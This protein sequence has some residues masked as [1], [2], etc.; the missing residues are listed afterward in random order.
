VLLE[1]HKLHLVEDMTQHSQA[2]VPAGS[3][4][5][6]SVD[7]LLAGSRQAQS[8]EDSQ[9]PWCWADSSFQ[10]PVGSFQVH[11]LVGSHLELLD[12]LLAEWQDNLDMIQA[13]MAD[14]GSV[15]TQ[16]YTHTITLHSLSKDPNG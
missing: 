6:E 10:V 1:R 3:H 12:S 14:T 8:L 9:Q 4:L 15:N 5:V 13:E 16:N 2:A 11:W 7:S